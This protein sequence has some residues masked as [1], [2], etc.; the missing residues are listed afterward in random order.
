[1]RFILSEPHFVASGDLGGVGPDRDPSLPLQADNVDIPGRRVLVDRRV[2]IECKDDHEQARITMEY[3]R[4]HAADTGPI[5][6]G[7]NGSRCCLRL[8][9]QW[10]LIRLRASATPLIPGPRLAV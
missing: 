7:P 3:E 5:Y 6:G 1:M 9:R 10:S 8:E 2:S 4:L